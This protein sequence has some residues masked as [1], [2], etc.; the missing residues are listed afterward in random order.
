M[1][2][3]PSSSFTGLIDSAKKWSKPED[4][5]VIIGGTNSNAEDMRKYVKRLPATISNLPNPIFFVETPE[6]HDH[7]ELNASIHLANQMVA[8]AI[9]PTQRIRFDPDR[10]DFTK[11]GLHLNSR[12]KY[13]LSKS[14]TRAIGSPPSPL[15]AED[16]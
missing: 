6:R 3:A 10:T 2:N 5:I 14:I 11:H 1:P 4:V 9:R 12:G 16:Y 15:K 8:A 13:A 7:P